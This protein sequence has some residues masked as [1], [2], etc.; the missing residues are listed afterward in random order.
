MIFLGLS[1]FMIFS[2]HAVEIPVLQK[3]ESKF[4]LVSPSG[5]EQTTITQR[6]DSQIYLLRKEPPL[7]GVPRD[8][9]PAETMWSKSRNMTLWITPY[10]TTIDTIMELPGKW[11]LS[12]KGDCFSGVLSIWFKGTNKGQSITL[13]RERNGHFLGRRFGCYIGGSGAYQAYEVVV[14]NSRYF[15]IST[16]EPGWIFFDRLKGQFLPVILQSKLSSYDMRLFSNKRGEV[17][18]DA[19]Y[20]IEEGNRDYP[21]NSLFKVRFQG[22]DLKASHDEQDEKDLIRIRSEVRCL[23][24]IENGRVC[25]SPSP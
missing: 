4:V 9:L 18:A 1:F 2:A 13:E 3:A 17:F 8:E 24:D 21:S 25:K 10:N 20:N 12:Q 6:K 19:R 11:L 22:I 15:G 23:A 16:A 5:L 14:L 7:I